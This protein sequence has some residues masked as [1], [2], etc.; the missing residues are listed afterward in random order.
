VDPLFGPSD[1]V[2]DLGCGSGED[3]LH[4]M[5]SGIRVCAFDNSREMVRI[6]RERGV[7]AGVLPIEQIDELV[8]PFDGAISN[9]GALNCVSNLGSLRKPLARLVRPGGHLVIC[10]IGRFCPWETVW[11]LIHGRPR[12]AVRRWSGLSF[13]CSVGVSV[14]Y[15]SVKSVLN[16]F[17]PDFELRLWRGIGLFVP[18][19]YVGGPT[20][21]TIARLDAID[22]RLCHL[23][24]LRA[25]A[26]HRL[27]VFVRK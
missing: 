7:E 24:L 6:A 15:P 11:Y 8:G 13:S 19:S 10:I 26:D 23:P 5:A 3:A 2:L 1:S 12:K 16:A 14:Y 27:F 9:F 21:E 22:Q 17:A 20:R 25:S 4:L 18:P